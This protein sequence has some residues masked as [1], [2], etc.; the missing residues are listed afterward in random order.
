MKN[1]ISFIEKTKISSTAFLQLSEI[2]RHE[3]TIRS[4]RNLKVN[5]ISGDCNKTTIFQNFSAHKSLKDPF[6][7]KLVVGD[8]EITGVLWKT[9]TK[10][11]NQASKYPITDN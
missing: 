11:F 6:M 4:W 1:G 8:T 7:Q 3:E 2:F 10:N 9:S 5:W